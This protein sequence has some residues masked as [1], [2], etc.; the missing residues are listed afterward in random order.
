MRLLIRVLVKLVT[1]L[2]GGAVS[3]LA[4]CFVRGVEDDPWWQRTLDMSLVSRVIFD[5]H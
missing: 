2:V 3:G 4:I 5:S 1:C